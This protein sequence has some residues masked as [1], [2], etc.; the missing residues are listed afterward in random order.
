MVSNLTGLTDGSITSFYKLIQ[1]NNS[2]TN[3]VF[4]GMLIISLTFII[5]VQILKRSE[6]KIAFMVTSFLMLILTL[7]FTS[8]N[9]V[10]P[11]FVFIFA[12]MLIFSVIFNYATN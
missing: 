10:N 11:V 5:L 9:L 2:V 4:S 3:G 7:I 12:L 6:P 8:I 1:Y